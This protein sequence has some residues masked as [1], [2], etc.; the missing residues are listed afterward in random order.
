MR[1]TLLVLSALCAGAAALP[2]QDAQIA[3]GIEAAES[4]QPAEALAY[5]ESALRA[6]ST[7][8]E[9]NWRA[10]RALIDIG[11]QTPDDRKSAARDSLYAQA[12]RYARRAVAANPD[13]ADGHFILSAAIG[14]ASL[15]K[16]KKERVRRAAEIRSEALRAVALD[17]DHD[18]AYHVLGRWHAE[19]M[20]LS[21]I[22]R[23]FAKSFL[24]GA[25]FNE[26]SWDKAVE[27]MQKAVALAPQNV[28]HRYDLAEIYVDRKQYAKAREQLVKVGE[29]PVKDVMDPTY[30]EG[31]AGLL[32]SIEGKGDE[33]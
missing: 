26:A 1:A 8:Y 30:K 22:Q 9:A 28:Y 25:I 18:G 16:G 12:E 33:D 13:G 29:L 20:R 15:T 24:G 32:K 4:R 3:R 5:F 14:R 7:S 23:F 2:A 11:K 31:A 10:A 19:I 27:N 6:D 21:G 17:P